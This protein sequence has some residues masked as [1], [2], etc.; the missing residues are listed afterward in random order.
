ML[1]GQAVLLAL[2][3]GKGPGTR[4]KNS[5]NEQALQPDTHAPE[6]RHNLPASSVTLIPVVAPILANSAA[7]MPHAARKLLYLCRK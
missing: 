3:K 5:R 7:I 2:G 4:S 6:H 1:L